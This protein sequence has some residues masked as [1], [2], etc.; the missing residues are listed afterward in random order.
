MNYALAAAS[1]F[2]LLAQ[3]AWSQ[4]I[5]SVVPLSTQLLIATQ[6]GVG[7]QSAQTIAKF[8]FL[9]KFYKH[10]GLAFDENKSLKDLA[11]ELKQKGHLAEFVAFTNKTLEATPFKGALASKGMIRY[12]YLTQ[13]LRSR[14]VPVDR[15]TSLAQLEQLVADKGLTEE[16]DAFEK[17]KPRK[18]YYHFD[19]HHRS[20]GVVELNRA[21]AAVD[22]SVLPVKPAILMVDDFS[23]LSEK[24][25]AQKF[26]DMK[27]GYFLPDTL[28]RLA[29]EPASEREVLK[30]RNWVSNI[31]D[32]PDYVARTL[33]GMFMNRNRISSKKFVDYSQFLI[34]EVASPKFK[35]LPPGTVVTDAL[36]AEFEKDVFGDP[37]KVEGIAALAKDESQK[38]S[39]RTELEIL[40]FEKRKQFGIKV[41]LA[42]EQGILHQIIQAADGIDLCK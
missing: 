8:S 19:G 33:S 11:A 16:F 22:P 15:K 1:S 21:I 28:K 9:A 5:N 12:L 17:T 36:I 26:K 38:K 29:R 27:K 2:L 37:K 30:L 4:E 13:F 34:L 42:P 32:V 3:Q 20:R 35:Q 6:E 7:H 25:V 39:L 23:D 31:E 41:P 24:Q 10:K 40:H 14:S 18:L